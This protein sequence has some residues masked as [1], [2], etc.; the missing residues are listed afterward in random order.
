MQ[1]ISARG[2]GSEHSLPTLQGLGRGNA[3][4]LSVNVYEEPT[5]TR[6]ENDF[7]SK[8]ASDEW[9]NCEHLRL[10]LASIFNATVQKDYASISDILFVCSPYRSS[11]MQSRI[12]NLMMI[13]IG[14]LVMKSNSGKTSIIY[15]DSTSGAAARKNLPKKIK[16]WMPG[17]RQIDVVQHPEGWRRMHPRMLVISFEPSSWTFAGDIICQ[18]NLPA[19]LIMM[20]DFID[21]RGAWEAPMQFCEGNTPRKLLA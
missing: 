6:G 21:E 14:R 10:G 2:T 5:L 13:E 8:L 3:P 11:V 16:K 19:G 9:K 12:H 1:G 17:A 4:K 18:E 20:Q 15:Q 7:F